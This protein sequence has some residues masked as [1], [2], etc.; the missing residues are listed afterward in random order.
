MYKILPDFLT[1]EEIL[2]V[3]R[4]TAQFLGCCNKFTFIHNMKPVQMR[5]FEEVQK[6]VSAEGLVGLEQWGFHSDYHGE[7]LPTI[8]QDTDEELRAKTGITKYPLCSAVLYLDI[9]D[10]VG[11]ELEIFEQSKP[12]TKIMPKTGMVV[13]IAPGTWHA[14]KDFK[15][16]KRHSMNYNYWD[17]PLF[18]S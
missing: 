18:T 12:A 4:D 10:L 7:E 9:Q 6:F 5:I 2:E 15:S 16:G 11:A 17:Y 3:K 14:I 13:L 1:E 8:H